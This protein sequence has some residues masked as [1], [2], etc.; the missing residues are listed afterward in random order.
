M[1]KYNGNNIK[2]AK[3]LRKNQTPWERKLW[4]QFLRDYPIKFY[5]QRAI[6]N[7]IVDF[8]C[9]KAKLVIELDGSKHFFDGNKAQDNKRTKELEELGLAVLRIP[10]NEVFDNFYNVCQFIDLKVKENLR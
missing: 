7:Y 4:Y 10:N 1:K 9:S 2:L 3:T 5:R 8:Y 6:G